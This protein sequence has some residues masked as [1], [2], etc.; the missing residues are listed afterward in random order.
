[1]VASIYSTQQG[2]GFRNTITDS[3]GNTFI[4]SSVVLNSDD[5]SFTVS[6]NVYDSDGNSFGV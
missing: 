1:M 6:S 5:E 3:D 2:S 4:I